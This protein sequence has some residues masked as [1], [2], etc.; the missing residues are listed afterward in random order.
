MLLFM[1]L[2][3]A[4]FCL[5]LCDTLNCSSQVPLSLRF[6]RQEYWSG[7]PFPSLGD[8]FNPGIKLTSPVSPTL[9][10]ILY[11]PSNQGMEFTRKKHLNT[12][13]SL[14]E[15]FIFSFIFKCR[16]NYS[17]YTSILRWFLFPFVLVW[18]SCITNKCVHYV[19][20]NLPHLLFFSMV[21]GLTVMLMLFL[22]Y[23]VY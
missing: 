15:S 2:Y 19:D 13:F 22:P 23:L 11:Q 7:L 10:V 14:W 8:L 4:Q 1:L 18:I 21:W 6:P 17:I 3:C 20:I 5:S 12:E 16:L 9:H